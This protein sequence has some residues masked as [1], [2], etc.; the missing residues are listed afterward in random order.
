M[1]V[2][3]KKVTKK[4]VKKVAKKKVAKKVVTKETTKDPNIYYI[5][6]LV[7]GETL[8]AEC[9]DLVC[10]LNF[11]CPRVLKTS[12]TIKIEKDGKS[13]D[14][15]LLLPKAKLMF[16]SKIGVWIFANKLILK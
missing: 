6:M 1:E 14:N 15:Y 16:R 7:N 5:T 9:E 4:T 11:L 8:K 12:M 2:T 13:S 3:K 10:G